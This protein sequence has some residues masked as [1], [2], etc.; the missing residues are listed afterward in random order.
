MYSKRSI[1]MRPLMALALVAAAFMSSPAVHAATDPPTVAAST[2][3]AEPAR[4]VK[5][6]TG[7]AVGDL[8]IAAV[9]VAGTVAF[10]VW[11]GRVWNRAT[12]G[13]ASPGRPNKEPLEPY[14]RN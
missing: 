14:L 7:H 5:T 3:N 12:S 11:R 2:A 4:E 13:P 6:V 10:V 9:A 8:V 1:F